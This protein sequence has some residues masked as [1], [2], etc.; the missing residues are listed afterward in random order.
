M[1]KLIKSTKLI[2]LGTLPLPMQPTT[3]ALDRVSDNSYRM[4]FPEYLCDSDFGSGER[5]LGENALLRPLRRDFVIG[6]KLK[7]T[8]THTCI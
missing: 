3:N 8:L 1:I 6:T 5:T 7:E 4:Y 2:E